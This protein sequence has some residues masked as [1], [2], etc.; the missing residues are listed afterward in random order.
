MDKDKYDL[1][2]VSLGPAS[3]LNT[4]PLV[5]EKI[6]ACLDDLIKF[7]QIRMNQDIVVVHQREKKD[8]VET[9]KNTLKTITKLCHH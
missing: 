6:Y 7:R 9:M 1:S 4:S 8:I 3:G 5:K 2:N